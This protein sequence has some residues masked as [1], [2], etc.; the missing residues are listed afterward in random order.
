MPDLYDPA[1]IVTMRAAALDYLTNP[2]S[3]LDGNI[4]MPLQHT[5]PKKGFV[6]S[7]ALDFI[8]L[9]VLWQSLA[10]A[11]AN[12]NTE[13]MDVAASIAAL[14]SSIDTLTSGTARTTS[15]LSLSLVAAGS[16]STGGDTGTQISATKASSI[17]CAVSTTTTV[18]IGGPA[19]SSVALKICQTNNA[20]EASWAEVARL[21]NNQTATLAIVLNLIQVSKGQLCADVPAG[22][23]A[24]L[25]AAGAGTHSESY[26]E[27]QKT[28]YG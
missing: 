7:P 25:V 10:E 9:Q 21:E 2:S 14:A 19:T 15:T 24:K 23:Y 13:A 26:I 11:V 4:N 22:W 12:A 8:T 1:E 28:I 18:T 3:Y 6:A 5:C 27:G 17:R 16:G 20:T